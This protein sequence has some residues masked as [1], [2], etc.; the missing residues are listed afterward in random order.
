[1]KKILS[2]LC[3]AFIMTA[4]FIVLSG[5]NK[6]SAAAQPDRYYQTG[7]KTKTSTSTGYCPNNHGSYT[8][9]SLTINTVSTTVS[10]R[11]W[12]NVTSV[13]N[14][15]LPGGGNYV[16]NITYVCTTASCPVCGYS[17]T[18]TCVQ[19][20]DYKE[21]CKMNATCGIRG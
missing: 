14:P 20:N 2:V 12:R 18:H 3:V 5:S 21:T 15:K 17:G 7:A 1:M 16:Y 13:Y 19:H 9:P 6:A 4:I 8:S 11:E 10:A